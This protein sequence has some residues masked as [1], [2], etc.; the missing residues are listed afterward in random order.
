MKRLMILFVVLVF[1]IPVFAQEGTKKPA[2][3]T[4]IKAAPTSVIMKAGK[5]WL[6]KDGVM[7][8]LDKEIRMNGT[9]VRPDGSVIL[10][11]GKTVQLLDGDRITAEGELIMVAKRD[12]PKE[13]IE[14]DK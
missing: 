5:V 4:E 1:G 9:L 13:Q 11:D 2:T 8:V 10:R 7:T 6:S 14:P 12:A 3:Q